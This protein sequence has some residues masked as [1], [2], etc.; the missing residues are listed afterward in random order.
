M[1]TGTDVGLT[2]L[3]GDLMGVVRARH[4]SR[5]RMSN[6][7]QKHVLCFIYNAAGF[8]LLLALYTQPSAFLLSHVIAA[9]AITLSSASVVG[10]SL[11]LRMTKV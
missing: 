5:A 10:N 7:T 4:F 2:L 9:A 8:P 11:R 3:K 6:I 1:G